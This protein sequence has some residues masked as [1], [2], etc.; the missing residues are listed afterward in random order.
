MPIPFP[1][2]YTLLGNLYCIVAFY[3]FQKI[4]P[5]RTNKIIYYGY[6][7][8]ANSL[9]AY[10]TSTL[11]YPL[12]MVVVFIFTFASM[13][14][15]F[16]SSIQRNLF[17]SCMVVFILLS[18]QGITNSLYCILNNTSFHILFSDLTPDGNYVA[19]VNIVL[20]TVFLLVIIIV[21]P[22]KKLLQAMENKYILN[23]LSG[24]LF[25][26][27]IF[28]TLASFIYYIESSNIVIPIYHLALTS[29]LFI[30]YMILFFYYVSL[31]STSKLKKKTERL[32]T[33]LA[34]QKNHYD[35]NMDY[36]KELR[37]I[38]HDYLD[39]LHSLEYAFIDYS[40]EELKNM[41]DE[42][43]T[44]TRQIDEEYV[45]FSNNPLVDSIIL[46]ASK[47]FK[48]QGIK[49]NALIRIAEDSLFDE[50]DICFTFATLLNVSIA[51]SSLPSEVTKE[52]QLYNKIQTNWVIV[53]CEIFTSASPALIEEKMQKSEFNQIIKMVQALNGFVQTDNKENSYQI[54]LCMPKK[55]K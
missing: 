5:I 24:I 51:I 11:I 6:L 39:L 2:F 53:T 15:F 10:I 43:L 23:F 37:K 28:M 3:Y 55:E 26:Y 45:Q 19:I 18:S 12:Q 46:D 40:K 30:S 32:E 17:A 44:K 35:Q 7:F 49:F 41:I 21:F 27:V 47:I 4:D 14:M 20:S 50:D 36:I 25:L 8:I 33:Q 16:K 34:T 22:R 54:K 9:I 1:V 13:M 31:D 38:K 42:L 48:Q 52:I 29:M